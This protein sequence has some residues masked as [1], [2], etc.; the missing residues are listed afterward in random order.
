MGGVFARGLTAYGSLA[1]QLS[2]IWLQPIMNPAEIKKQVARPAV[3]V[4]SEHQLPDDRGQ[5]DRQTP[6]GKPVE[7]AVGDDSQQPD[8]RR[9]ANSE[10]H[11]KA[12]GQ[13]QT[14]EAGRF[15]EAQLQKLVT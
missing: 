5:T 3:L 11:R 13:Q 1:A 8:E 7:S 12:E 9:D 10:G 6:P 4:A 14:V 15:A 2:I